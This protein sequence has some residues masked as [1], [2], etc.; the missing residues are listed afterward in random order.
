MLNSAPIWS[1]AAYLFAWLL[2]LPVPM[3]FAFT[4]LAGAS[5]MFHWY[6]YKLRFKKGYSWVKWF[7]SVGY[8]WQRID[9]AMIYLTFTA[10]A[11][12]AGA[13][14]EAI[15]ALMLV[16]F[17]DLGLGYYARKYLVGAV[18]LVAIV[19]VA[20]TNWLFAVVGALVLITAVYFRTDAYRRPYRRNNILHSIWH[21]NSAIGMLLLSS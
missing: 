19:S 8:T 20:L 13:Q 9:V 17:I 21:L 3:Q 12:Y 16:L 18:A 15:V 5:A 14:R 2:P 4:A 7:D 6:E 1:N 10:I 11:F